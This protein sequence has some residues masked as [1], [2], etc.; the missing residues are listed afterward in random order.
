MDTAQCAPVAQTLR[1][2]ATYIQRHGWH[3]GRLFQHVPGQAFPAACALGAIVAAATGEVTTDPLVLMSD[4]SIRAAVRALAKYLV[5]D[6]AFTTDD[7]DL[8]Q[9][10]WQHNDHHDSSADHIC[11][12]LR[13]AADH[14]ASNPATTH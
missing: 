12:V 7:E 5:P 4:P 3:R 2:A 10:I 13:Q 6:L 8:D 1:G 9:A 14:Y 11:R